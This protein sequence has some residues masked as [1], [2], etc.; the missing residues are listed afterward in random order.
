MKTR[1]LLAIP[2]ALLLGSGAQAQQWYGAVSYGMSAPVSDTK[3]FT[4]GTSW[5]NFGVDLVAIVNPN[6]TVGVSFAWNVFNEVTGTVSSIDG[7]EISGTQFRYIN[8]LP[9]LVTVR[10]YFRTPGGARPFIGVGVGPHLVKQRVDVGLWTVSENTWHFGVAPE[11]GLLMPV[12]PTV[13]WF[14]DV[15]YNY[16]ASAGDP[17]RR[18][19][20]FAFNIGFAWEVG[21]N[22]F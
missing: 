9:M 15:K 13:S 7:T 20:Y 12:G 11:V 14:A 5:R 10:E 18:H 22:S 2:L 21:G 1:A 3:A 16:A 19:S 6:T 4:R 8:S 17:G